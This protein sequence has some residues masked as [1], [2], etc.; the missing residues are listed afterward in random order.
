MYDFS[1]PMAIMDYIPVFFFGITMLILQWS[2]YASMYKG[3][4][5]LLAAGTINIFFAGFLKATWK[6]FYAAGL[7]DFYFLNDMFLPFQSFGFLLMGAGLMGMV[8]A[9]GRLDEKRTMHRVVAVFVSIF[10][11]FLLVSLVFALTHGNGG[12]PVEFRGTMIF[13]FMMVSGLGCLC[14]ILSI[15]S[16]R[17]GK[18]WL[19]VFFVL[20]F[21]LSL[22]MGY[23]SSH[24]SHSAA[25]NWIEESVNT[26]SQLSLMLGTMMLHK[27][28][29]RGFDFHR[30]R[31]ER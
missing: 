22:T 9:K 28:G 30:I 12:A 17:L 7:C 4:Y 3:A 19:I 11:V 18:P 10:A 6:F 29:L 8:F 26:C 25:I 2:L 23:L 21:L 20:S 16:V 15:I 24:D 31:K 5:A 14:T 1:I 27:N 13:I